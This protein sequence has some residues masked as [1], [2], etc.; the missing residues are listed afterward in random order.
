VVD[1]GGDDTYEA[2]V[3]ANATVDNPVSV[4]VDLG[5]DDTYGYP[6]RASS[7]D[8]PET[9]PS[10]ADGRAR[11]GAGRRR[12]RARARQGSGGSGV[13]L[14]YDLGGGPTATAR[15]ACRRASARWA[16][17]AS[18]TTAATTPTPEAGGQ[19][20]AVAGV[21]GAG[22]RRRARR[23]TAWAF[24]QGFAYVQGVGLL[25]DRDGDD[26]YDSKVTPVLYRRR[27][28][29]T[30]NSSFTQGAGFGRRGDAT[31]TALNMSGGIGVLRDRAGDD[32]Y[33]AGVFAQ[34]TGYWGGMGC[35]ST[36]PATTATT[37][38]GTC[39]A[40][41]RTSPTGALVD[42]GGRDTFTT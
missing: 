14:L 37:R 13:A 35:C 31:P 7:L 26:V 42:G 17:A 9:L 5:G 11:G 22:R 34:G 21:G 15:C 29:P 4:L 10:D 23:Y 32:R 12:C 1:L 16:W 38:A 24:A 8:T 33:T 20:A 39:R 3:A 40:P 28:R 18:T 41:R 25:Y 36:A 27:S 6:T 30:V 2:P 19:G